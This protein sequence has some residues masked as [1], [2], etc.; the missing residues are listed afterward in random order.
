MDFLYYY[1]AYESGQADA[2]LAASTFRPLDDD[3]GWYHLAGT[4]G[5]RGSGRA[6]RPLTGHRP[7]GGPPPGPLQGATASFRPHDA[8]E[9]GHPPVPHGPRS[10]EDPP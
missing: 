3:T 4:A 2:V 8:K 5:C 1:V 7:F 10:R 6:R 9:T